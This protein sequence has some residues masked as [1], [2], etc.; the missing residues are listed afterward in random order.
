MGKGENEMKEKG[1]RERG[2]EGQGRKGLGLHD[3]VYEIDLTYDPF[4]TA[5]G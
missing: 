2:L 3:N 1:V 5:D 4:H